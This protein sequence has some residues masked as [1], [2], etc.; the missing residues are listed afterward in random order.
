ME[1]AGPEMN[2]PRPGIGQGLIFF[3][4]RGRVKVAK[5]FEGNLTVQNQVY[6][7]LIQHGVS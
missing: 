4:L 5:A 1:K 3:H 7:P 6:N 2:N